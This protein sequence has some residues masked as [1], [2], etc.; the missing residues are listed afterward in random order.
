MDIITSTSNQIAKYVRSLATKKARDATG[1]FVV[2]GEKFLCEIADPWETEL[3]MAS[4]SFAKTNDPAK[5]RPPRLYIASDRVFASISDVKQ[6]RGLLGVV[7]QRKYSIGDMLGAKNPLLLLLEDMQDPGNLGTILRIAHG[8]GCCGVIL[9]QDCADVYNPKVVRGSAGSI[10]HV[11]FV[12]AS[13]QDAI[14]ALKGQGV[15]IY[16]AKSGAKRSL[17]QLDFRGS[18]AFVIGNEARGLSPEI[19]ALADDYAGIPVKSESL[20]ASVACGILVYEAMRQRMTA[21]D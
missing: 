13:L 14:T 17:H 9:S 8:L 1:T 18:T 4:E 3:I 11:P 2:E 12:M 16:A 15:R 5:Y 21:P 7:R 10:F 20:N 19:A 6:P